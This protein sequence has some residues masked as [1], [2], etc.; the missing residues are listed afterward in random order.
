MFEEII[1]FIRNLYGIEGHIPL[2][3]PRFIGNEK[4]YLEECIDSAFVSSVGKFVNLFEEKIAEY[5]GAKHAVVT[6]NGTEALHIA[7]LLSGVK[8]GDEVITQPLTFIA[9]A[10]SIR[11]VNAHPVFID[12]D[13]DTLGLSPE[14]LEDFII[15]NTVLKNEACINSI[16]GRKISACMPMHTFGHPARIDDI[17]N[18]CDKYYISVIEDAAESIGS[19]YKGRHTGTFGMFG[20]LSFNGNKI[21]TTGGG[22]MILT[23]DKILAKKAKHIT[24]QAKVPHPWE[25]I[26]DEVGYNYRM[27]NINAALGLAQ[28]ENL[29]TFITSKR[30]T[31]EK[32]RE[33]FDRLG[34]EFQTEPGGAFSNYW[35]NAIYF[36]DQ[37]QRDA[38]LEFSNSSGVQCRP[39]WRLMNK[40]EM[41]KDLLTGD[42]GNAL[43]VEDRLVNIPSSVIISE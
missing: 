30:S 15:K 43:W 24:T 38:F 35:L 6:V 10:N 32:Y 20:V 39:A 19:K 27:P 28:L 3:E 34:I 7:L 23:N 13:R 26:H 5:T 42:L 1:N 8:A 33:F 17:I 37:I 18:I 9:T 2:H 31:A 29:D 40:L 25:Y 21:L 14:K 11:Y 16:T 4:K 41:Y 12:I 36:N 22:G